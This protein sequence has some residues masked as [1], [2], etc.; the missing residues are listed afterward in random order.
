MESS[1]ASSI[2]AFSWPTTVWQTLKGIFHPQELRDAHTS[3]LPGDTDVSISADAFTSIE[4][5]DTV[6]TSDNLLLPPVVTLGNSVLPATLLLRC[7][8]FMTLKCLISSRSVCSDWRRLVP[9]SEIHPTRRRFLELYDRMLANPFF[10]QS[11][12]W[13]VDNLEPFDRQAYIATLNE[14]CTTPEAEI[15]E[16]FWMYILEWPARMAIRCMWPGL[17]FVDSKTVNTQRQFGINYLSQSPQLSALVFKHQL[18]EA[19]FIPGLLIWRNPW[20]TYW[21]LFDKTPHDLLKCSL[22][23]RVF[24]IGLYPNPPCGE[25]TNDASIIPYDYEEETDSDLYDDTFD[26][27]CK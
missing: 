6:I 10:L 12:G 17:P 23:G 2:N 22:H 20:T 19:C 9:H 3:P 14:Q 25:A 24:G 16:D 8:S 7:F 15:P 4:T 18:P 13:T 27:E 21:L 11:R 1:N 26:S 5:L